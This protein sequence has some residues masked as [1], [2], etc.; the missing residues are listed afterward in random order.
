M[1]Y[2]LRVL[3]FFAALL[4]GAATIFFAAL[5]M[6]LIFVGL[7]SKI[8][9]FIH[10]W[11]LLVCCLARAEVHGKGN[12]NEPEKPCLFIFNHVSLIDIPVALVVIKKMI[13]FGA[14]KEL[15]MIP[16]FG[17]AMQLAGV[18][19]INRG[20]RNHA[21]ST[22]K[23]ANE[24]IQE[25]GQSFILAAEG[26]RMSEDK[27]GEFKSGPFVLA[28]DSQC[29]LVPVVI[30]GAYGVMPKKDLYFRLERKHQVFVE[31]LPAIDTKQYTFEQRHELKKMVRNQMSEAFERLKKLG[32]TV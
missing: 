15:F 10:K 3:G 26:T 13:R 12:E 9:Y 32:P 21:I 4:A 23:K 25:T 1:I 16:I 11:A 19:R 5:V 2:L 20:D 31:I 17:Q 14:K 29:P 8:D 22:L 6:L 24:R 7:R 27:L 30:S 18:L 28:I